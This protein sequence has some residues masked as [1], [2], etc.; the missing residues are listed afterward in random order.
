MSECLRRESENDASRSARGRSLNAPVQ[1]IATKRTYIRNSYAKYKLTSTSVYGIVDVLPVPRTPRLA[2]LKT[3]EVK[4][5]VLSCDIATSSC[6]ST[7]KRPPVA[8]RV[9]ARA[10]THHINFTMRFFTR[11]ATVTHATLCRGREAWLSPPAPPLASWTCRA[12]PHIR[13]PHLQGPHTPYTWQTG[14]CRDRSEFKN[15]TE[16][17]RRPPHNTHA[18][19]TDLRTVY[20]ACQCESRCP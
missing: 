17:P 8:C 16:T 7:V 2:V 12:P 14:G 5:S 9:R 10:C 13:S 15:R 1:C 20:G 3:Q 6:P 4:I 11:D 19:W 18:M